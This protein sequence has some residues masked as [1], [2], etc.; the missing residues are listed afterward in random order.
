VIRYLKKISGDSRQ[1]LTRLIGQHRKT[2]KI[3]HRQRTVPGFKQRPFVWTES[4]NKILE[5]VERSYAS[6]RVSIK[7]R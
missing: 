3:Q 6:F 2:G 1:Q 5:K 7:M 4:A